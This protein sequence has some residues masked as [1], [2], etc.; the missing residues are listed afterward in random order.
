LERLLVARKGVVCFETLDPHRDG[1]LTLDAEIAPD[2]ETAVEV[3]EF[4]DPLVCLA[5]QSRD[6]FVE[7]I[8]AMSTPIAPIFDV[9]VTGHAT[10]GITRRFGEVRSLEK[11]SIDGLLQSGLN[12]G[13]TGPGLNFWIPQRRRS[14]VVYLLGVETLRC[15]IQVH[16]PTVLSDIDIVVTQNQIYL[17]FIDVH[18]KKMV[19]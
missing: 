10:H 17:L 6:L 7:G 14:F 8:L 19:G 5:I 12:L 15:E 16:W 13:C 2:H 9:G 1:F 11:V 4:V 18:G 3:S